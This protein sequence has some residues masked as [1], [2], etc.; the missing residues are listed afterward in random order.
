MGFA[1]C[2]WKFSTE[3]DLAM[4]FKQHLKSNCKTNEPI[5]IAQIQILVVC[6]LE[7]VGLGVDTVSVSLEVDDLWGFWT[8]MKTA[9]EMGFP[10]VKHLSA[11]LEQ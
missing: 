5:G 8:I 3:S 11:I 1:D 2:F 9:N 10:G 4:I 7:L 6:S